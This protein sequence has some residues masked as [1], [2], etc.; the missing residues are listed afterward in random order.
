L[1]SRFFSFQQA[2]DSE[3]FLC[4]VLRH[5]C[6]RDITEHSVFYSP[7]LQWNLYTEIFF[8]S[9]EVDYPLFSLFL[10]FVYNHR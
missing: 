9:F 1:I 5:F 2:G 7:E 3:G 4:S 8:I 6:V 10:W